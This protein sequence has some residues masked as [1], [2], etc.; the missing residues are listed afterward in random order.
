MQ[1]LQ[2]INH[3]INK[4]FASHLLPTRFVR[5]VAVSKKQ[6]TDTIKQAI[7]SGYTTFAENYLQ[8]AKQ[9]WPAILQQHQHIELQFIGNLQSNK[10]KDVVNLFHTISTLNNKKNALLLQEQMLK[11]N[12]KCKIFI[13][14]N[15]GDEP[16]KQGIS[17]LDLPD[18]YEFCLQIKLSIA[19]IMCIAPI[20][21]QPAPYFALMQKI[22]KDI[23]EISMGMS[24]DFVEAIVLGSNE[25][26]LGTA[27]FNNR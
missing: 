4:I 23:G 7:A 18:L 13:Q 11:Q 16:Q 15:I 8:E 9:K 3:N 14:V 27:I 19:G 12:K 10:I 24:Q 6:N 1:T 5:V 17:T 2:Q 22:G 25:I 21:K 26:R 20:T